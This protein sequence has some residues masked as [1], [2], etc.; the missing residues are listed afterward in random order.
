MLK[1]L[2][3]SGL[4]DSTIVILWGDHGWQLGEHGLWCKHTNFETSTLSPLIMRVP[5]QKAPGE[6]APGEV[7]DALVEFVD[8]YP[9]LAELCG[10]P[11]PGHLEGTSFAPLADDPDRAW[12]SAAFSEYPRYSG[13]TGLMGYSMRTDRYRLTV[14]K[15]WPRRLSKKKWIPV[16]NADGAT[17]GKTEGVELYDH[18]RDPAEN[19]NLAAL[20]ENRKLVEELTAKLEAGWQAAAI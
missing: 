8:I 6:V 15:T 14:W 10:L 20:P 2:E 5:G 3:E 19:V 13:K 16:E 12:K 7:S 18:R 4:A 1:G 11:L 9:T 17:W